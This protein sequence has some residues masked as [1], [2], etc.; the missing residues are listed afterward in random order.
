MA[1][2]TSVERG[3]VILYQPNNIIR[4]E[5]RIADETVWLS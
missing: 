5:V 2:N 1:K 4:L 3:E